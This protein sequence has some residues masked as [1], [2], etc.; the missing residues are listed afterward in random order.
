MFNLFN[1]KKDLSSTGVYVMDVVFRELD[2]LP[3]NGSINSIVDSLGYDRNL[4][5]IVHIFDSNKIDCIGVKLF[6][7]DKT[8][9][10]LFVVAK[11]KC[12]LNLSDV[13]NQM[14][15]VDWEFEYSALN[16][17]DFLDSGI[18]NNNLSREYLQEFVEL[19]MISEDTYECQKF[20]LLL[21][22]ENDILMAYS[23]ANW[24]NEAS[25]W[26]KEINPELFN[27]MFLEAKKFHENEWDAM[28]EVNIQCDSILNTPAGF[29]NEFLLKHRKSTGN[30][31]FYNLLA[32][33]YKHEC[34]LDDFL[35]VNKGRYK[36]HSLNIY[37]CGDYLFSFDDN[38]ILVNASK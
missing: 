30:I 36:E 20:G 17:A 34:Y 6:S 7:D 9:K 15:K 29:Q 38:G 26:L 8:N 31:N 23:S 16:V 13:Y 12:K 25:R 18:E 32:V 24:D 5:H 33:H 22:F 1:R 37:L 21:R 19:T 35:F 14:K 2:V 3:G 11:N 10:I 28:S 4:V 27:N